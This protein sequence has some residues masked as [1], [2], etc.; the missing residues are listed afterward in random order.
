VHLR[1]DKTTAYQI[2]AEVLAASA[3]AGVTRIGFV[4]DPN[5]TER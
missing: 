1:A 2:I 3:N 4:S 5:E